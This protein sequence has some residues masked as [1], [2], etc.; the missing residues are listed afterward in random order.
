MSLLKNAY[1]SVSNLAA[2][3]FTANNKLNHSNID[4][5]IQEGNDPN[6]RIITPATEDI[7][8]MYNKLIKNI[9]YFHVRRKPYTKINFETWCTKNKCPTLGEGFAFE[10]LGH[11]F[12]N[13]ITDNELDAPNNSKYWD[14]EIPDWNDYLTRINETSDE[15][16]SNDE[17]NSTKDTI[18]EQDS[19]DN[20]SQE[21][22]ALLQN[23]DETGPLSENINT[24]AAAQTKIQE[25]FQPT[26][27]KYTPNQPKLQSQPSQ[28]QQQPLCS[29]SLRSTKICNPQSMPREDREKVTKLSNLNTYRVA[30]P[31]RNTETRPAPRIFD[32]NNTSLSS[33]GST[34]EEVTMADLVRAQEM[35][36]NIAIDPLN[37]EQK[38]TKQWFR[39]FEFITLGAGWDERVMGLKLPNYLRGDALRHWKS[40]EFSEQRNYK[41]VK[42][43]IINKLDTVARRCAAKMEYL[44]ATQSVAE[45][46]KDFARRL[47]KLYNA[48]GGEL[49][50][51]KGDEMSENYLITTLEKG[52]QPEY[53]RLVLSRNLKNWDEVIDFLNKL[54]EIPSLSNQF[55]ICNIDMSTGKGNSAEEK[56]IELETRVVP[57]CIFC[58]K[59]GH[60]KTECWKLNNS[61]EERCPREERY[62]KQLSKSQQ[63]SNRFGSQDVR[64]SGS[65][66]TTGRVRFPPHSETSSDHNEN[67]QS[68]TTNQLE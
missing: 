62:P 59:I 11:F 67:G 60:R 64:K 2:N 22:V 46:T 14:T 32:P 26:N 49:N 4:H 18:S 31:S 29:K 12:F 6:I 30:S 35:D 47:R 61:R 10:T 33:E 41:I 21:K 40:L 54:D 42:N 57:F 20:E 55:K 7:M 45:S 3:I 37:D 27:S 48:A 44:N 39:K 66:Q 5:T 51:K 15:D 24:T 34:R 28:Q 17:E 8:K 50:N 63:A 52:L 38:G 36:R 16:E 25:E 13:Y 65:N 23:R 58:H 1:S 43:E 56:G 68:G 19:T 9:N 53:S